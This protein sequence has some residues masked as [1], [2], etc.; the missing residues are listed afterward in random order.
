MKNSYSMT[1]FNGHEFEKFSWFEK[2]TAETH[3]SYG[4]DGVKVSKEDWMRRQE[5]AM[6][7]DLLRAE[8]KERCRLK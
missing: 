6:S 4:V 1:T 8:I 5:A 2:D 3:F 7:R